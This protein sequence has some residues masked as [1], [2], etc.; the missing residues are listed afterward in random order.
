MGS[1]MAAD[2][3]G[4]DM[5][6]WKGG[7][8]MCQLISFRR[9]S[10]LEACHK[11]MLCQ[12]PADQVEPLLRAGAAGDWQ[13][14]LDAWPL[15]WQI[16][17]SASPQWATIAQH[18]TQCGYMYLLQLF[19]TISHT[20]F[21]QLAPDIA[22]TAIQT[23]LRGHSIFSWLAIDSAFRHIWQEQICTAAA[24]VG[25]LALM[26]WLH[27]P[28]WTWDRAV[29][30]SLLHSSHGWAE[31]QRCPDQDI[32]SKYSSSA[33]CTLAA[34][35]GDTTTLR[36]L[37]L[38]NWPCSFSVETCMALAETGQNRQLAWLMNGNRVRNLLNSLAWQD[39][40]S[41]L[42]DFAVTHDSL[43]LIAWQKEH[44]PAFIWHLNNK[45]KLAQ[46]LATKTLLGQP[47]SACACDAR[48]FAKA[49]ACGD[50]RML[51]QIVNMQP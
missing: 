8:E 24:R 13:A 16:T 48:D 51:L 14:L 11:E 31:L 47:L 49:A 41:R 23:G 27:Q 35:M 34:E 36:K 19:D 25:S 38:A 46:S 40:H 32:G 17:F 12:G 1:R 26:Q 37:R 20:D 4:A 44:S 6:F 22:V 18:A 3:D 39:R 42:A 21:A 30:A 33:L 10:E 7:Q 43:Q 28:T 29:C 2:A 50:L 5:R 45:Y 15:L 9:P